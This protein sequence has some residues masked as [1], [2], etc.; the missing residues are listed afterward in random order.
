M[1]HRL[2]HRSTRLLLAGDTVHFWKEIEI[3]VYP[4]PFSTLYQIS[5]INK[6]Y[7][8]KSPLK[9]NTTFK[10]VFMGIITAI[11]YK[12]LTKYTNFANFLLIAD[13]YSKIPEL[14]G[15]ENITTEEVMDKIDMFQA[16]FEKYMNLAGGIRRQ[17]KLTMSHILPPSS[18]R[19]LFMYVGYDLY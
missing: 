10:W 18:F 6:K 17:S 2:G 7:R 1:H 8:S 12:S 13:A 15:M 3:R 16:R 14:Y 11:S 5:T 9:S 19:K 4:D